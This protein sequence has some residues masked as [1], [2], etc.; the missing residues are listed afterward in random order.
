M[1][2]LFITT[3]SMLTIISSHAMDPTSLYEL[4]RTGPEKVHTKNEKHYQKYGTCVT[5]PELLLQCIKDRCNK[6]KSHES[7]ANII[8]C[9]LRHSGKSLG[10]IKNECGATTFHYAMSPQHDQS[11]QPKNANRL[12]WIKIL[13]LIAGDEAWNIICMKANPIIGTVLDVA[14]SGCIIDSFIV[15]ELLSTAPNPQ[16]VWNLINKPNQFQLTPLKQAQTTVT[17]RLKTDIVAILKSYRPEEHKADFQAYMLLSTLKDN[18][19]C[20]LL[21]ELVQLIA[22]KV[23]QL[24]DKNCYEK[25]DGERI[26]HN[27]GLLF[28]FIRNRCATAMS[29]IS[30]ANIIKRCLHHSGKSLDEIKNDKEQTILHIITDKQISNYVRLNTIKLIFLIAEKDIWN[31][32][33]LPRKNGSTALHEIS[34]NDYT[35]VKELLSA[36]PDPQS[37]WNLITKPNNLNITSLQIAKMRKEKDI[38]QLLESYCPKDGSKN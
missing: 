12:A 25:H 16:A 11:I 18:P 38:S 28:G 10:D 14:I 2:K 1:R 20:F 7:T 35:S 27:S 15:N 36:A 24:I 34:F 37:A 3:L 9:C 23:S 22:I 30:T 31:I 5:H 6:N 26:L 29:Y 19:E 32:I 21:P 17:Q 8:K 13:K 33:C 4:R